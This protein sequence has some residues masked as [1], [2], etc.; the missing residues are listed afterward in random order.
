MGQDISSLQ[1]SSVE[2]NLASYLTEHIPGSLVT[3]T[4][5][6]TFRLFRVLRCSNTFDSRGDVCVK[7]YI[8]SG[9]VP[10]LKSIGDLMNEIKDSLTPRLH[11]HIV[12]FDRIRVRSPTK[13]FYLEVRRST[14]FRFQA[15][16]LF[17]LDNFFQALSL[18]DCMADHSLLP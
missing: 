3:R 16:L 9:N 5:I 4:V 8:P 12:Y 1:N 10:E 17:S 11:P 2:Q 15:T 6:G 13:V 14:F 18:T 7:L